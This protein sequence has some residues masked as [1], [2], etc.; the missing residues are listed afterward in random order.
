MSFDITISELARREALDDAALRRIDLNLLVVFVMVVK[1]GSV[2]AAA[3]RLYLGPSGVSMALNRLR[4]VT[5][6]ALLVRGKRG[7]E[8]TGFGR[9]LFDRVNPALASIADAM[10]PT[11]FDPATAIGPIRLALSDDLEIVL[12]A[13]LL[14]VLAERA[15][16]LSLTL[17][18]GDYRRVATILDEDIAD[19]VITARPAGGE[20]RHRSETLVQETFVVLGHAVSLG[21]GGTISMDDYLATPHALVSASGSARGRIDELLDEL[22]LNRRVQVVT[23][24]FAALPFLLQAGDLIAN[25]PRMA[26]LALAAAHGLSVRALPFPGPS[27][28]I[29]MTWRARDQEDARLGW[30][31]L[32]IRDLF[33]SAALT[34]RS[35][36]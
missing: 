28:P 31:R 24:S 13:R 2:Q 11:T 36:A 23:E 9:A 10:H 32:V 21:W 17:R 25:V 26:G 5:S 15:P 30:L 4:S 18:H 1:C 22:G 7:L 19:V 14:G 20:A 8:P 6:D 12:A 16:G 33:A 29:A 35:A 3:G 34:G 27:F